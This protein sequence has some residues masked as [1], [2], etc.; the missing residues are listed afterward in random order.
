VIRARKCAAAAGAVLLL[1]ACGREAPPALRVGPLGFS[2]EAVAGLPDVERRALGDIAAWGLAVSDGR[3]D[4]L[5]SA[6]ARRAGERSRLETLSWVLGAAATG[7][8]EEEL[9]AAYAMAPEWELDV[10]HV[11]RLAPPTA[12]A[13]ERMAERAVAEEVVRRAREGEDFATLAAELSEEPGAARRGGLLEPGREGSW[14]DPFWEAA[15]SLEP[16]DVSPVIQTEFGF[17]VLRLD[18][19]RPVPFGEADRAEVLRRVVPA[20]QAS[21]AMEQW[22]ELEP[23]P[24]FE[25][26]AIQA[27]R[28]LLEG[29]TAPDTVVL[30]RGENDGAYTRR[31]L[32]LT[33]AGLPPDER[34][35]LE[36]SDDDDF[37]SWLQS[38]VRDALWSAEAAEL[39][40][41]T[42][43]GSE[44]ATLNEFRGNA[45]RWSA[46]FGFAP[47]MSEQAL[48][49]AALRGVAERGQEERIARRELEALRPFLRE[50]YPLGG[51]TASPESGSRSEISKIDST[52]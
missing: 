50:L 33:W 3:A 38:D 25:P 35:R 5:L 21:R 13:A 45:A 18:D 23:T 31:E 22:V 32:A 20:N 40:A 41:P 8:E 30:A 10:R 39:G 48:R 28:L 27:A 19:R 12:P 15:V 47:A 44:A 1:I 9:A 14:V 6:L 46:T 51:A 42:V 26:G 43:R 37:R 16:G 7:I 17:H 52:G 2:A 29:E 36:A 4:A 49:A 34:E 11:V 24:V